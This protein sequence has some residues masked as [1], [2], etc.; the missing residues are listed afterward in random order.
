MVD[1]LES[2][3]LLGR[4]WCTLGAGTLSARTPTYLGQPDSGGAVKGFN[5][6][7]YVLEDVC[8]RPIAVSRDFVFAAFLK[9]S[10]A[11]GEIA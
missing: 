9:R 8:F 1:D 3:D 4:K 11:A 5:F 2:V 6:S 10:I 7:G